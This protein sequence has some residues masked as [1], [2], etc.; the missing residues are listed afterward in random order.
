MSTHL[1]KPCS[2]TQLTSYSA[3][4]TTAATTLFK[5]YIHHRTQRTYVDGAIIRNNPVRLACEESGR[6]WKSTKPPDIVVSVGTGILVDRTGAVDS[7]KS[8]HMQSL[9][10]FLPRGIKKKV[11]TGLDMVQ[12]TLDCHREWLDFSQPLRGRPLSRNCHR[13]DVGLSTKPP[14][15]DDVDSM[16]EL[17]WTGQAYLRSLESPSRSRHR[18]QAIARR[19]LAT[20][21][22]LSDEVPATFTGGSIR[23]TLH[24]RLSPDSD[25]APALI[26]NMHVTRPL[27]RIREVDESGEEV[28]RPIRF[29]E[30]FHEK[31]MSAPVELDV[32]TGTYDRFVEVQFPSRGKNWDAIGGF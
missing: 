2:G 3:R 8:S 23:S 28:V 17:S 31:T 27:F 22:Y 7:R 9:K 1:D 25:G 32:S 30:K 16:R 21:F 13:L 11:E 19:L 29:L 6:I 12:A 10:T 5:P 15:L 14:A 20:L 18:I 24:C 26:G 4:A